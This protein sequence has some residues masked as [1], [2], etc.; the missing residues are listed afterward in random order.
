MKQ[1]ED[2]AKLLINTNGS[3]PIYN[4]LLYLNDTKRNIKYKSAFGQAN[5]SGG[6]VDNNYRFRTGSITKT[7]TATVILQLMEEGMLKLDDVYLD[8]LNS[9]TKTFFKELMLIDG[10]NYSH[11][12]TIKNLLQHR[13]GIRDYFADDNRFLKYIMNFPDQN[14]QWKTI[15]EKY[16]EYHLNEK[17]VFKPGKDFYYSDTN[18][19]LLA[20]LIEDLTN[21]SFHEVLEKRI[22]NPLSLNDTYL[23]FYQNKKGSTPIIF[24]FH[25]THALKNVNT[26]FDWGGG[27]LISSANDLDVFIRSLLTGQLFNDVET[28]Q[29]MVTFEQDTMNPP[30]KKRK[31]SYGMG[32]QQK[33]I[34]GHNFIGHNSAY[35]GMMFY[36]LDTKFSV[37]L[38]I[39]QASAPHKSEWLLKKTVEY[40]FFL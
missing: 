13:S 24:P 35:G 14:W 36:D 31:F 10:I 33:K 20:I 18:Y 39:N 21:M 1:F 27:G 12:V 6:S 40:F 32:L 37:I 23:E 29:L 16:F 28:L 5:A 25:G 30:S 9:K 2:L 7:F 26:S 4:C 38:A 19:L 17:G 22:L 11:S 8:S 3:T 15:M 34:G